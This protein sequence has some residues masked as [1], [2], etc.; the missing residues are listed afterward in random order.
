MIS[1]E[2]L[3]REVQP[4][5]KT[6]RDSASA[7]VRLQKNLQKNLET[8]SLA[9][10]KRIIDTMEENIRQMHAAADALGTAL[11]GF[12]TQEYFAGGDF[13]RQLLDACTEKGIN[14]KGEK[15]VYEMFP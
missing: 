8:G 12:N 5:G 7:A 10:A 14:V 3:L 1:Y 2:E 4:L 13:A 9:E 11:N 15:G 6:L